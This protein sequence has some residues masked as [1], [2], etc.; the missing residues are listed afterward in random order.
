MNY[1]SLKIIE[2]SKILSSRENIYL[3]E[4]KCWATPSDGELEN[5]KEN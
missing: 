3:K 1:N 2:T 5:S 4:G